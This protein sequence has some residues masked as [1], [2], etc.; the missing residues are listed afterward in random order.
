MLG[1]LNTL[2]FWIAMIPINILKTENPYCKKIP[3]SLFPSK[4][5]CSQTQWIIEFIIC[6]NQ[7][8]SHIISKLKHPLGGAAFEIKYSYCEE[9]IKLLWK[10]YL[11]NFL[12]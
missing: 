4:P 11:D 5:D 6:E 7:S 9:F 12:C 8:A 3:S 10:Q 2:F 1:I